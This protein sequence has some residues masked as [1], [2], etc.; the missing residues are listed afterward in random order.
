MKSIHNFLR[1]LIFGSTFLI[2][3]CASDQTPTKNGSIKKT[4][5][6]LNNQISILLKSQKANWVSSQVPSTSFLPSVQDNLNF[7]PGKSV[8]FL[9]T[10]QSNPT[11]NFDLLLRFGDEMAGYYELTSL[12]PSILSGGN[13]ISLHLEVPENIC[14][15]LYPILHVVSL[16]F[17][18]IEV[19]STSGVQTVSVDL[20]C[21]MTI[22]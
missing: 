9:I 10:L 1:F 14:D 19:G 21:S 7:E 18:I 13:Q 5:D 15:Y 20:N 4:A 6:V 17:L 11:Q 12:S 3:S 16:N 8:Q 2:L 22:Q